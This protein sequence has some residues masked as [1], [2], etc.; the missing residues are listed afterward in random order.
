[1][2]EVDLVQAPKLKRA[3]MCKGLIKHRSN[4]YKDW[5]TPSLL[6]TE[7]ICDCWCKLLVITQYRHLFLECYSENFP[8]KTR[9]T[10]LSGVIETE[11]VQQL[12]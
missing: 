7:Y 12:R 11:V 9:L 8:E 6:Y 1:M 4:L 10:F 5:W 2:V 3:Y